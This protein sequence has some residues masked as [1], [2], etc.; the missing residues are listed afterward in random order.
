MRLTRFTDYSL[1]VL[2]YLGVSESHSGTI[3]EITATYNISR[4][5][6]LKVVGGLVRNH[7]I[8][9]QRGKGGGIYLARHPEEIIIGDVVRRMEGTLAVVECLQAEHQECLLTPNCRLQGIF[10]EAQEQFLTALDRYTLA[11]L[12]TPGTVQL[13]GVPA[14]PLPIQAVS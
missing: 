10:R 14:A 6:L 7:F 9:T 8:T 12:L 3:P 5:H 2:M 4:N 11:D 13:L 1:R